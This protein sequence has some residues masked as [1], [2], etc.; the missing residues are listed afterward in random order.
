M[1]KGFFLGGKNILELIVAVAAHNTS[2]LH[3][4]INGHGLC[5][6]PTNQPW[7]LGRDEG[8]Q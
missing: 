5:I 8:W 1:P 4:L 6:K 2:E 3:T 7:V